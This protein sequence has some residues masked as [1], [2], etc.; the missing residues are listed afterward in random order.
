MESFLVVLSSKA[1]K[2]LRRLLRK[3]G[4]LLYERIP[5]AGETATESTGT[6]LSIV[7]IVIA[8]HAVWHRIDGSAAR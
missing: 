4:I 7:S 2:R 6:V 8:A 1:S 3:D 5:H